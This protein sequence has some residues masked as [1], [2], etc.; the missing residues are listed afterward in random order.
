MWSRG[1]EAGQAG[2]LLR[3]LCSRARRVDL[4]WTSGER[5]A[6]HKGPLQASSE[7]SLPTM[8]EK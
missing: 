4:R 2:T 3:H 7:A 6:L 8:D 1:H 5:H